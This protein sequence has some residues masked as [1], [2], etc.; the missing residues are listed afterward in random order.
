MDNLPKLMLFLEIREVLGPGVE[1]LERGALD[2]LSLTEVN[3]LCLARRGCILVTRMKDGTEVKVTKQYVV[4][5]LTNCISEL[6]GN[7]VELSILSP[8]EDFPEIESKKPLLGSDRIL[9]SMVAAV[10]EKCKLGVMIPYPRFRQ[11]K[12]SGLVQSLLWLWEQFLLI[13]E[14]RSRYLKSHASLRSLE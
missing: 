10:S 5:R 14:Q 4:Q 8:T 6:E 2:G 9:Q 13:Q 7:G 11:R 1:S 12:R 3:D